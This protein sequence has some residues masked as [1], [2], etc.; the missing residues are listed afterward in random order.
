MAVGIDQ[1]DR[2]KAEKPAFEAQ[3]VALDQNMM[4]DGHGRSPSMFITI[5]NNINSVWFCQVY[6]EPDSFNRTSSRTEEHTSE[7]QSLMRISYAVICLKKNNKHN[8][9]E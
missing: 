4:P 1:N 2:G 6:Y 9:N 3:A 7:L 5:N 8:K